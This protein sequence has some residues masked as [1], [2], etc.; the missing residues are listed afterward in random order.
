MVDEPGFLTSYLV[1]KASFGEKFSNFCLAPL[2]TAFGRNV[3]IVKSQS[4]DGKTCTTF[5]TQKVHNIGIRFLCGATAVVFFPM[6]I[7]GVVVR[8]F[9][10]SHPKHVLAHKHKE[11]GQAENSVYN[12]VGSGKKLD[13]VEKDEKPPTYDASNE[14]TRRRVARIKDKI[15]TLI[16]KDP[17]DPRL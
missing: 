17:I 10:T 1:E 8:Y 6:T 5:T 13:D 11:D 12:G 16:E 2:V 7:A 3:K 9:S 4:F 15:E 14:A